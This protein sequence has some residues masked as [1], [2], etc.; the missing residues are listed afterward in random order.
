MQN[1][2][3][4]ISKC[5][6]S[7]EK[8]ILGQHGYEILKQLPLTTILVTYKFQKIFYFF[9]E[10]EIRNGM[11]NLGFDSVEYNHQLLL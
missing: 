5:R 9:K 7:V 4:L 2:K 3:P 1:K 10:S 6:A 11:H 8:Y